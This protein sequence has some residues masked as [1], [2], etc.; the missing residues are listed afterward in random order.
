MTENFLDFTI[1]LPIKGTKQEFE[2]AKESIPSIL[3]LHPDE[4]IFGVDSP[5]DTNLQNHLN[6]ICKTYPKNKSTFVEVEHNTDWNMPLAHIL[7]DC[8]QK[9]KHDKILILNVDNR[10][11]PRIMDGY[12]TV[13]KDNQAI[14]SGFV[15][16][17][18]KTLRDHMTNYFH[19]RG[20]KKNLRSWTGVFWIYRPWINKVLSRTEYSKI[21]NGADTFIFDS[22]DQHSDYYYEVIQD[23]VYR[24]LDYENNDLPWQQFMNGIYYQA[25]QKR[26]L[27]KHKE[28]YQIISLLQT[29]C[30]SLIPKLIAFKRNHPYFLKGYTWAKLNTNHKVVLKASQQTL[31]QWSY[32]GSTLIKDI[33]DWNRIGKTGTG[34]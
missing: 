7:Y 31:Y 10:I 9:A 17:Y 1:I 30:P 20:L 13:G 16:F 34:Y 11:L 3:N 5:V 25:N 21:Y 15:K 6:D 22:V 18:V 29:T 19:V 2:F 24:G 4:L 8:I 33:E 14:C 12:N 32:H 23:F 28:R 27:Q 26:L